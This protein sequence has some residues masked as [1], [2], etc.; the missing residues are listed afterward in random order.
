MLIMGD[1]NIEFEEHRNRGISTEYVDL[2]EKLS[3]IRKLDMIDVGHSVTVGP[4]GSS[5]ALALDGG[6]RIDYVFSS[7][8][9]MKSSTGLVLTR[10]EHIPFLDDQVPEG[11]LSDH[12]AVACEFELTQQKPAEVRT[13]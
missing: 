13:E 10:S 8:S 5:D 3:K 4:S 2:V 11:S 7:A 9:A 6:R 12:L 1:F